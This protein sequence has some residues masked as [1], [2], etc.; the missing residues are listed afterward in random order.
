M[1]RIPRGARYRGTHKARSWLHLA[2][3]AAGARENYEAYTVHLRCARCKRRKP[4]RG[5]RLL[6]LAYEAAGAREV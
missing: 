5:V 2:Y 4:T 1:T 6:H 3:E